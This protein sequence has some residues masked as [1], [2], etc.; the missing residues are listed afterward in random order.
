M[1][2]NSAFK[3]LMLRYTYIACIVFYS[4]KKRE[5]DMIKNYIGLHVNYLLFLSDFNKL[6]FLQPFSKKK[7]QISNYLKIRL[8]GGELFHVGGQTD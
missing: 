8:R 6:K 3:G 5:R 7:S 4:K 2:F 1:G